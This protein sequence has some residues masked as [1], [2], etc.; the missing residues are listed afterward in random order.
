MNPANGLPTAITARENYEACSAAGLRC[1][2]DA[3]FA[4]LTISATL[5]RAAAAFVNRRLVDLLLDKLKLAFP[6]IVRAADQCIHR[7]LLTAVLRE[8][9][10]DGISIRN[11]PRILTGVTAAASFDEVEG[12]SAAR[13][14]YTVGGP[15]APGAGA[16]APAGRSGAAL[17]SVLS[18]AGRLAE[19]IE[20]PGGTLDGVVGRVRRA[21]RRQ[22][23]GQHSVGG[24]LSVYLL[25][26]AFEGRLRAGPPLDADEKEAVAEACA[27]LGM[28]TR[29]FLAPNDIRRDAREVLRRAISDVSVLCPPTRTSDRS[30][31]WSRS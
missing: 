17:L 28:N 30:R 12:L 26:P 10:A 14:R 23:T 31:A 16:A 5:R 1:W 13:L 6:E 24:A 3:G 20:L 15:T 2:G 29:V 8:L 27:R 4:I 9:A 19:P 7:S 11:F 25:S 21:L 18:D 22:I